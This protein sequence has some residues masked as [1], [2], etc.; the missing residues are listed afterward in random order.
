MVTNVENQRALNVFKPAQREQVKVGD[1][2][3]WDSVRTGSEECSGRDDFFSVSE[4]KYRRVGAIMRIG[5]LKPP[6][7]QQ[8]MYVKIISHYGIFL[9]NLILQFFIN[10]NMEIAFLLKPIF[11]YLLIIQGFCK[12]FGI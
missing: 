10:F 6:K 7:R 11:L 9:C 2:R 3:S 12:Y 4:A 8:K 5:S 1:Q